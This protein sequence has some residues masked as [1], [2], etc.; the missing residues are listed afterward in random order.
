MISHNVAEWDN[1]LTS[2]EAVSGVADLSPIHE[3]VKA[4]IP[5]VVFDVVTYMFGVSR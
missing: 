2:A 4:V 5:G 1:T 3:Q